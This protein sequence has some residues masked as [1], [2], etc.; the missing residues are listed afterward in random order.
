MDDSKLKEVVNLHQDRNRQSA[1][2]Y[3]DFSLHREMISGVIQHCLRALAAA[4]NRGPAESDG[5]PTLTV[6][7]AGNTN[8]LD[9][10]AIC[11]R[12]KMV[13]LIDLDLESLDR[14]KQRA[15]LSDADREKLRLVGNCDSTGLL[16]QLAAL[17]QGVEQAANEQTASF[18]ADAVKARPRCL[19]PGETEIFKTD[20]VVSACMLSQLID[21]VFKTLGD[22]FERVNDVVLAVRDNHLRML[23]DAVDS[24]SVVALVT[25]FVSSD[26]LPELNNEMSSQ[27][28]MDLVV[29]AIN[30][31]NFFTGAN[32][33]ALQQRLAALR[34]DR[35]GFAGA[36]SGKLK[37]VTTQPWRWKFGSRSFA[38]VALVFG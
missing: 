23:L 5:L 22:D 38:A 21:S 3:E 17:A 12:F 33:A 29:G 8:D 2:M 14:A 28:F 30:A 11:A 18:I 7:G 31:K 1:Q 25:D 36:E 24:G 37:I 6:W 9:L 34:E 4:P 20:V 35:Q 26:T 19:S 15:D 32:P 13:Q 27:E 16:P 10:P